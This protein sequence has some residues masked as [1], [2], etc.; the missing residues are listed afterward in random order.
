MKISPLFSVLIAAILLAGCSGKLDR[1]EYIS[2]V[3]NYDNGLHVQKKSGDFVFDLQY[4]PDAY[5]LLQRNPN[6][7][8]EGYNDAV[9]EIE[10]LQYYILT[11]SVADKSQDI[12]QYGATSEAELQRKLYYFSYL[13][14]NDIQ[15]NDNGT[16]LPC[17]LYHF[18]RSVDVKTGRTFVLAFE[19]PKVPSTEATLNI[20]AEPFGSLPVKIKVSKDNIP[21]LNL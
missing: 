10:G 1:K 9:K 21:M 20:S 16:T 15:L 11:V 18:E 3:R 13:F 12:V 7:T 14:Q 5:V 19:T 4:Q 8:K 2:W 6:L 17:V